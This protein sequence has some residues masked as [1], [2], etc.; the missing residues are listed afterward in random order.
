MMKKH[1]GSI[2]VLLG[3]LLLPA[4][5]ACASGFAI[6][7]QSVSGLGTAFSGVAAVA[8]DATTVYFNPAGMTLL[9]GQ[10]LTTGAHVIVP[11]AKFTATAAPTNAVGAP[12]RDAAGN[13]FASGSSAS[14]AG[15]IGI[16][17]NL[18]YTNKLSNKFSVG[19]GINAPF[20]LT[21]KYDR[22]WAGRYHAVES[23][24]ATIN[25]NPNVA[26]QVND[27]LSIA[28]GV[29]AQYIDV[30]LSSMVDG[31]LVNAKLAAASSPA[32]NLALAA[33]STNLSNPANDV[34]VENKADDW[35]YG[36]NLGLLYQF[37]KATRVGVSYRSEI[38]HKVTGTVTAD[39]PTSVA[40]LDAAKLFEDQAINGT[41][42][43]P[44]SA[45]LSLYHQINDRFALMGDVSW[46]DWSSFDKLTI[47]FEGA[48]I[49]TKSNSTTTE[50]WEDTWR[51]SIG[52]TFRATDDLLLRT[53][54]AYDET[55]ILDEFRTP[56][57]PGENRTWL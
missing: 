9:K 1:F 23:A 40:N 29:N 32:A 38:K 25:I 54:L 12:I 41:I 53:G 13:P 3:V 10:Q 39:V 52:A 24:V 20:G 22:S 45:S 50:N 14:N 57:I 31:G 2:L 21:T 55:P 4:S 33:D 28:A 6:I 43:L 36:Y 42:T 44:A 5:M 49:A 8:E 37:N 48:G 18:Y 56:R 7:E 17:P 26:Y 34:F 47:N 51:Y 15:E 11:S 35:S 30:T 46:T 19:L 27:Q 16:V